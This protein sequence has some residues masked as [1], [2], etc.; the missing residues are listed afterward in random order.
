MQLHQDLKTSFIVTSPAA[1]SASSP[2]FYI[3]RIMSRRAEHV[4]HITGQGR[5]KLRTERHNGQE[6]T[7]VTNEE[8]RCGH[9]VQLGETYPISIHQPA[10]EQCE[11]GATH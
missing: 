6:Y 5:R 4:P 9:E 11:K 10:T 8:S 2:G 7:E 3:T 1:E